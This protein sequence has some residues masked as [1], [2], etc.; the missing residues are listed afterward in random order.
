MQWRFADD[1]CRAIKP[2]SKPLNHPPSLEI[3]GCPCGGLLSARDHS[4]LLFTSGPFRRGAAN[5]PN[6]SRFPPKNTKAVILSALKKAPP[7]IT[8]PIPNLIA[9]AMGVIMCP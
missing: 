6:Q 7:P 3:Q 9:L 4:P 5:F 2:G 1:G 8:E